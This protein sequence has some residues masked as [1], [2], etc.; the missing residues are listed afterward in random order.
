MEVWISIVRREKVLIN[1][2]D[3]GYPYVLSREGE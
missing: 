1:V 2:G 3:M